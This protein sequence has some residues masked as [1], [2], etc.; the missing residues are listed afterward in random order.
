MLIPANR[1]DIDRAV[2]LTQRHRLRGYDAVQLAM[3]LT[4]NDDLVRA[5]RAVLVFATADN[6]LLQAA[7]SEG[8]ATDNPL[9]YTHLD[10]PP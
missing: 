7:Q 5:G 4:A 2:L 9:N 10:P 3:G 1:P 6:D 8:L